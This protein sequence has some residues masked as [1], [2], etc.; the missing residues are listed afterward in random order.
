MGGEQRSFWP[1]FCVSNEL[2]CNCVCCVLQKQIKSLRYVEPWISTQ[3][4]LAPHP[5]SS[6]SVLDPAD[7]WRTEPHT[8][9]EPSGQKLVI[10]GM[11]GHRNGPPLSM[12]YDD[13][14]NEG[15]SRWTLK[16][17]VQHDQPSLQR[18]RLGIIKKTVRLRGL[19][20]ACMFQFSASA[21]CNKPF[22]RI[23]RKPPMLTT[24]VASSTYHLHTVKKHIFSN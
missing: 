14:C 16:H 3:H 5:R 21:Y 20:K 2:W 13:D 1:P 8:A 22:H 6:V 9:S 4:Y 7:R 10:V 24:M 15:W 19:Q 23:H 17:S 18:S 12:R 11:A